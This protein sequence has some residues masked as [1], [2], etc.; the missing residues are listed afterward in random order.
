MHSYVQGM[1]TAD[2]RAPNFEIFAHSPWYW[3]PGTH[4][5][6]SVPDNYFLMYRVIYFTAIY[7]IL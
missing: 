5:G 2:N 6:C 1:R 7:N 3:V 4:N